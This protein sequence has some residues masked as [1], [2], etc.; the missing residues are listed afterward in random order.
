[1]ISPLTIA[2]DQKSAAKREALLNEM[3][4]S[5]LSLDLL[6]IHFPVVFAFLNY[7]AA[8][9]GQLAVDAI[10]QES[11]ENVIPLGELCKAQRTS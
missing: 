6:A 4:R 5:G 8:G 3:H 10:K 7:D 1:M 9:A 11:P 2:G